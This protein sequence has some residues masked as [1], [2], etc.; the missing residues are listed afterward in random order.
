M[1]ATPKIE[2]YGS[3]YCTYC[4]AARMLLTRKGVRFDEIL[5]TSCKGARREMEERC[6]R[7]SLPQI[8]IDDQPIGGFDELYTLEKSGKLDRLLGRVANA[9]GN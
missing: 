3:E 4:T 2:I 8:L 6:G 9:A 7:S 5:V 1:S